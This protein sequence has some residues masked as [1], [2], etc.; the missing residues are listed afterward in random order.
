[1]SSRNINELLKDKRIDEIVNPRLVQGT[2]EMTIE[3]A[4]TK[5]QESRAGY[6]VIAK[7][8]KV[9][10]IFTENDV[11]F[12]IMGKKVDWKQPVSE[13][14]TKDPFV[15]RPQDS[16]GQAMD[17]MAE[18]RFYHLPLVDDKKELAGVLSVRTLIRFLAEFYPTEVYNLPPNDQ[19]SE[20]AEG[21]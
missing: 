9:V 12:K 16:V 13:F 1:M 2:P 6:M 19:V 4:V 21:G 11:L 3:E 8:R 5:M 18:H 10:G 14:M 7:K 15:L 17:L 20:T